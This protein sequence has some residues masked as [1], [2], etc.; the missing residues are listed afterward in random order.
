[1]NSAGHT[2]SLSKVGDR[3]R[4][5]II[6]RQKRGSAVRVV[7]SRRGCGSAPLN[8]R[9]CGGKTPESQ[10]PRDEK[11]S[12]CIQHIQ[13]RSSCFPERR[14]SSPVLQGGQPRLK[15]ARGAENKPRAKTQQW[16][17]G[18]L[19]VI[20]Q[21]NADCRESRHRLAGASRWPYG[22]RLS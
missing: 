2:A 8:K 22:H 3:N 6:V 9:C 19:S 4:L 1:M 13:R 15:R 18:V 21:G 5:R 20:I 10:K 17:E 12:R 11:P 7:V 16:A 14:T